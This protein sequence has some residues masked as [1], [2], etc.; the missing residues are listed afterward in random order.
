MDNSE[1][2]NGDM[3][4]I[5]KHLKDEAKIQEVHSMIDDIL[6]SEIDIEKNGSNFNL[7]NFG[8]ILAFLIAGVGIWIW[9]ASN[10]PNDVIPSDHKEVAPALP[11]E[12]I[13]PV[14]PI[15][16]NKVSPSDT[17]P[18]QSDKPSIKKETEKE[19]PIAHQKPKDPKIAEPPKEK[20]PANR[21]IADN[22]SPIAWK[23]NQTRSSSDNAPDNLTTL[24]REKYNAGNYQ[25]ALELLIPL[26]EKYPQDWEILFFQGVCQL[27]GT[28]PKLAEAIQTFDLIIDNDD[29]NY[30]EE[31]NWFLLGALISKGENA[32]AYTLLENSF[33]RFPND[34]YYTKAKN[35]ETL[36]KK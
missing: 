19:H 29:N 33:L 14:I 35:L 1:L 2:T 21:L 18:K 13:E 7:R 23:N 5:E 3:E 36:L 17:E 24:I 31:A 6:A 10:H 20:I 27:Q 9:H 15:E 25:D 22:F 16:N 32:K 30:L 26:V 34:K 8:L 4:K 28:P 12:H 11:P